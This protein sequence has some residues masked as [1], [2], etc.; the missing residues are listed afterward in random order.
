MYIYKSLRFLIFHDVII[1]QRIRYNI[2]AGT[3]AR[4]GGVPNNKL[5]SSSCASL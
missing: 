5:S 2:I 1:S 3:S 4:V